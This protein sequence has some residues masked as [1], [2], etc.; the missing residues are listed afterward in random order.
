MSKS[1][2]C[3]SRQ[4]QDPN[5]AAPLD[6]EICTDL[7][8]IISISDMEGCSKIIPNLCRELCSINM[9][10]THWSHLWYTRSKADVVCK[11]EQSI[12]SCRRLNLTYP[13]HPGIR[14][15]DIFPHIFTYSTPPLI[16]ILTSITALLMYYFL[17]YLNSAR[18]CRCWSK[19]GCYLLDDNTVVFPD[20]ATLRNR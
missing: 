20:W 18:N 4:Y 7:I 16:L 10:N 5:E 2:S 15:G 1:S 11:L 9:N 12:V 8:T 14:P 17:E 19:R 6:I 3:V 13:L